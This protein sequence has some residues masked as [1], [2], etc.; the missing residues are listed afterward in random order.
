MAKKKSL[1]N[2]IIDGISGIFLPIVNLLSAA[3]I[4]KGVL[5]ILTSCKVLDASGN[6]Y[7]VLDAMAS[8]VFTFLPVMLAYTSA[9][10]FK[11]N[12]YIAVVIACLLMYPALVK[13]QEKGTTL[14]FFGIPMLG[15]KYAS[16][17]LPIIL[18]IGLLRFVQQWL[19]K[20]LPEVIRGF[21][22]PLICV[23]FV[24]SV[25]LLLFGPFG[26]VVGDGLAAGYEWVYA[27][28]PIIAGLLLGAAVQPMVIFGFH[29]SLIL[30]GMNNLAVSGHDTVL[31]LMGP[32]VFAQA[33]AALAVML[34]SHDAPF[35]TTC[36]SASISALFGITEPAMFGVNLPRKMPLAAVC[37]GGGVGGA[38][39]GY[40]GVQ[41]HA[42][43]LPSVATLPVFFGHGF[44]TYV[45]SCVFA[46]V[47]A[48][49]LTL[50][51][52]FPVDGLNDEKDEVRSEEDRELLEESSETENES[53]SNTE[54]GIA[55]DEIATAE[56]AV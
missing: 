23:L 13:V 37:I 6:T 54:V 20:V 48:F 18:A 22:T 56:A 29:W 3:G 14:S 55:A 8:C 11:T 43:A 15:V 52:K 25:T 32:P 24:G 35:K 36:I 16:S 1:L 2:V 7:L 28:S 50:V 9:K 19:D 10:Q 40:S 30:I 38:I 33:G 47:V 39:A 41:A 44:V 42:F 53:V 46:M 51:L 49:V 31:A 45:I 26:K 17:V 5:I 21:L 27:L 12:P 4:M 34:K